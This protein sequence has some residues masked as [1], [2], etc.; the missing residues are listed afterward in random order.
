MRAQSVSAAAGWEVSTGAR[1]PVSTLRGV[2]SGG[3]GIRADHRPPHA[4]SR[5]GLR[6]GHGAGLGPQLLRL[7]PGPAE[8]G[9][10][11]DG[12]GPGGWPAGVPGG[13]VSVGC[14]QAPLS[15]SGAAAA[16]GAE[17]GGEG[18]FPHRISVSAELVSPLEPMCFGDSPGLCRAPPG[19]SGEKL[20]NNMRSVTQP[21]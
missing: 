16:A 20:K 12:A 15:R 8:A 4:G 14:G 19:L 3:E 21:S 2:G 7:P 17:P 13:G 1:A 9:Q 10:G 18:Q 6:G 5:R 11:R